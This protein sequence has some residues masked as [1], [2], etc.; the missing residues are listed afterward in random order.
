VNDLSG[1]SNI[2]NALTNVSATSLAADIGVVYEWRPD[3]YEWGYHLK[4]GYSNE[5]RD[6]TKY[7]IRLGASILDLGFIKFNKGDNAND[8]VANKN[9]WDVSALTFGPNKLH[10]ID[11]MITN[12]FGSSN[13]KN[14]FS[15]YL[16]TTFSFQI[17]Y[18]IYKDL[19]LNFTSN[20]A[21][22]WLNVT[23]QV[24]TLSYYVVTPRWDQKWFGVFLPI[25][26][27]GYGQP[28]FG[29]TVRLGPLIVGTS[30]G[31]NL[32]FASQIYGINAYAALK[33]PILFNNPLKR[34][35][36]SCPA[37]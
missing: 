35:K 36:E 18:H 16:P 28:T 21:P 29:A 20:T 6:V 9:D 24:H 25:G 10:S 19:Y 23:S 33:V 32:L 4:R 37:F 5:R 8:F 27:N 1:N 17:D 26:I 12:N 13:N 34:K 11:T 2:G 15:F 30:N 14:S 7:K 3:Y 31:L 22:H